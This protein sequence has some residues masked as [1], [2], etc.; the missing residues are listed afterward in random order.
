MYFPY[1]RGKQFELLALREL[2]ELLGA[3]RDKVSPIIEP[4]K[5]LPTFKSTVSALHKK[6]INFS[7]VLNP[8]VGNL[9]KKVRAKEH[10]F[11]YLA[12]TVAD[13]ENYQLGIL[14]DPRALNWIKPILDVR[15]PIQRLRP[16]GISFIHNEVNDQIQTIERDFNVKWPTLYNV[17]NFKNT[18]R[19]Y[20]RRFPSSTVVAQDDYFLCLDKNSE[21]LQQDES[22]FSEEHLYY[23]EEGFAGFSDFL[24][25]G[26]NYTEG[27]FLPYAV[28]IHLS[29]ADADRRIRVKHFVSDSNNDTTDV[30]GKFAEAN[31]KLIDW[32]NERNL[33]SIA[34]EEFRRLST[35]RHFPGLGTIKKLSI[36]NHI[37]LVLSLI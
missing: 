33:K 27:G 25:I 14:I 8:A 3:N 16:R 1:L 30:A 24:T 29:F 28:A 23:K 11:E 6:D 18:N 15:S 36:M 13:F 26:D 5:E 12:S 31:R 35:S 17:I 19:R 32:C 4:V 34:I 20:Y 22:Q 2:S 21:Y 37:E 9:S 7:L 10:V